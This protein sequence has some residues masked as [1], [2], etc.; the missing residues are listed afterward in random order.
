[1]GIAYQTVFGNFCTYMLKGF[2]TI[3]C[4]TVNI[5]MQILLPNNS[6]TL[7][8]GGIQVIDSNITIRNV[9]LNDNHAL[10]GGGISTQGKTVLV[11]NVS[12]TD[13]SGS[14]SG[15]GLVIDR[16][17][18]DITGTVSL[19][20]N[21]AGNAGGGIAISSGN[22]SI[23]SGSLLLIDNMAHSESGGIDM[24]YSSILSVTHL[25]DVVLN[26]NSA[27]LGGGGIRLDGRS[28]LVINGMMNFTNNYA[29]QGGA[30]FVN[31]D[32]PL[33]SIVP[34]MLE[35]HV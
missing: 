3:T 10:Q 7:K 27:S 11:G 30:L 20:R 14:Y 9:L 28:Q 18:M 31:D 16:G 5:T 17:N 32:T 2:Q 12:I 35:L 21:S 25:G 4:S 15:G 1:M 13:N 22:I 8:G 24:Q 6:A 29:K 19:T 33:Y 26:N 23:L 34:R